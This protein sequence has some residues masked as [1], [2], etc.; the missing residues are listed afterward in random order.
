MTTDS[1]PPATLTA[2]AKAI[3]DTE[4]GLTGGEIEQLLHRLNMF[5]P[6]EITKWKRLEASFTHS[7]NTRR[8]AD[9][10]ITFLTHA[11]DPARYVSDPELFETRRRLVTPV[12]VLHGLKV[13]D[14]G[15]V[16]RTKGA[17]SLSDVQRLT[18][19]VRE[20]L[21]RRGT[22]EKVLAYCEE[23]IL[24]HGFLHAI[25]E[26]SKSVFQ[27]LRDM[28]GLD[29]DGAE[30]AE[31]ALSV[32]SGV[33]AINNLSNPTERNEQAGLCSLVTAIGGLYRNPAA[34]EPRLNRTV[35][36]TELYEALSLLSYV[37]RRLDDAVPRA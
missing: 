34:H 23:E 12:L 26:A 30:L 24:R 16:A 29:C 21:T 22:H 4:H 2:L 19:T 31:K 6:G 13:G 10:I 14:S 32:K 35:T 18:N 28:T 25:L 11:F 7:Q 8:N 20:E 36:E 37:H 27:R 17:S 15:K 3:G 5:D 33:L 9:R 1:F